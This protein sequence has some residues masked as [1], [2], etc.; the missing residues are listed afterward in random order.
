MTTE[1]TRRH[2]HLERDADGLAWLTFDRAD[3][4]TNSLSYNFV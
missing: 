4:S 3:S 1:T 2:W